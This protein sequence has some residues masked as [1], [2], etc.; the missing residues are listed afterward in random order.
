MAG[1]VSVWSDPRLIE[2][3]KEFVPAADE[4]WRLQRGEDDEC[5]LFQA[6]ADGGH[7]RGK[8]GT[9]QGIYVCTPAGRLLSSINSLSADKVLATLDEGLAAWGELDLEQRAGRSGN[10]RPSHRWEWSLPP[11]GVVLEVVS[12]D[13]PP[14]L[15]PQ[16]QRAERFNVD[17]L[18]MT[19][20]EG[21]DWIPAEPEVGQRHVVPGPL[22]ERLARFHLVDNVRGQTLPYAP[23]EIEQGQLTSQVVR[24]E[25]SCATVSLAGHVRCAT[26][27][28]W[29]LGESDWT[30]KGEWPRAIELEL[31]GRA[32]YDLVQRK[33]VAFSLVALGERS[34]R[35]GL[36][37]RRDDPEGGAIGFLVRL[38][39]ASRPRAIAPAFVDLYGVDWIEKP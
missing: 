12:R 35:T 34:G 10:A 28:V 33:F 20:E 13:L 37:G 24:L 3:S 16:G 29:R 31:R 5:R 36:N 8:G 19:Q 4:V 9:R 38:P 25:G 26:D 14:A 6:M 15:F 32:E 2:R 11:G 30:P 18:W 21:R 23:E 22:V 17:H 7:Y 27:G 1:R 39:G